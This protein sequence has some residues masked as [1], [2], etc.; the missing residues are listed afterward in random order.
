MT[1]VIISI[2][3]PIQVLE[4][5]AEHTM[6]GIKR[7]LFDGDA[8]S[9]RGE[10]VVARAY[11]RTLGLYSLGPSFTLESTT[12]TDVRCGREVHHGRH[13]SPVSTSI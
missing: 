9:G 5:T 2:F 3:R 13:Y 6:S 10:L 4:G 8:F 12:A 1:A 7:F 11:G